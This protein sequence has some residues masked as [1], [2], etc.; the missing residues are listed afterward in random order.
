MDSREEAKYKLRLS[1]RFVQEAAD[2]FALSHWRS[3]VSSAQPVVEN[4]S[5]AVPALFRSRVKMHQAG[6]IISLLQASSL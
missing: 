1:E 3:C 6:E 5:K 2:L 4:A